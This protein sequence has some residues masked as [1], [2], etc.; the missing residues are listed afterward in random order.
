M[1]WESSMTTQEIEFRRLSAGD[2]AGLLEFLAALAAA[3]DDRWF[4]PHPFDRVAVE[5]LADPSC[6]D[7]YRLAVVQGAIM[8]YGMLR[9][10]E[11]G[12]AV[13]SLGLAIHPRFRG[14]GAGRRLMVH[15]HERARFRGADTVR[16]KVYRTNGAAI[17]LYTSL[18]Y[19]FEP[20][21]E[22]EL[23]GLLSL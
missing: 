7:E 6:R 10:W 11:E 3:G 22:T 17:A 18:G 12:W 14:Q 4:H 23:L 8:G 15:L 1:V 13:P 20:C 5:R 9:G 2:V 19:R 21:S 16:L